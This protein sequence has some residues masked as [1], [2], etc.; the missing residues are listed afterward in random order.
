MR[1]LWLGYRTGR[2][3]ANDGS[4]VLRG[5]KDGYGKSKWAWYGPDGILR[6]CGYRTSVEARKAAEGT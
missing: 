6:G 1:I 3:V 2:Y 4:V 5:F